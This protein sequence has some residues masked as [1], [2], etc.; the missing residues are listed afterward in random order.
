MTAQPSNLSET[1]PVPSAAPFQTVLTVALAVVAGTVLAVAIL[2][3][4][5][6]NLA[7]SLLGAEPKAYWYLSRA[8]AIAAY[9]LLW[10]SMVMGVSITNKMAAIWPGGP[11]ARD[12]HQFTSLLGLGFALFHGLILMADA[13]ISFNLAQVLLP[14]SSQSYRPFWVGVGQVGFYLWGVV[15]LSFY[16]RRVIGQRAWR[17]L[18]FVSF[19]VFSAA[20]LHGVA[21]GTD[22]G[23]IWMSGVYWASGSILAVLIFYRVMQ[24]VK[25]AR[26]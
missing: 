11:A 15:A 22:S 6:P 21:S 16:A 18:H 26:D 17:A 9:V 2:P 14:F 23:T 7:S 1:A 3:T 10:V 8:T 4:W 20:M 24:A 19:V 5:L 12:M 13:Y 25:P